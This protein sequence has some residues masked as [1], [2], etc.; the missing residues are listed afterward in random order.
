MYHYLVNHA[1]GSFPIIHSC[2]DSLNEA[3]EAFR[4]YEKSSVNTKI[5]W[6]VLSSELELPVGH[7]IEME[8]CGHYDVS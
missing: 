1:D 3:R 6:Y 4:I 8:K 5:C 7:I 2:Y